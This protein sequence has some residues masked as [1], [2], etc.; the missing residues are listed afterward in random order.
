M[1]DVHD[2]LPIHVATVTPAVYTVQQVERK[3]AHK[4]A[5]GETGAER[6]LEES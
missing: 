4:K 6:L 2:F 3:F 1:F 5:P